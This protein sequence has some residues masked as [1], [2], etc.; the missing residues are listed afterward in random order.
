MKSP[1]GRRSIASNI[2]YRV[3]VCA[4]AGFLASSGS[5]LAEDRTLQF[6]GQTWNVK[7][8]DW[9]P[10]PN[11]WSDGKESVY[12][13]DGRR[14]HLK[15]RQIGGEW[16]CAE[17]WT[18]KSLG[19]G[20]YIFQLASKV[21][22]YDRNIVLGLFTYLDDRHEI[23]IE[24]ARWGEPHNL[25]A[26]FVVQPASRPENLRRFSLGLTGDFSTHRFQWREAFVLFQSYHG[27][28]DALP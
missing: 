7:K 15:I 4:I 26:Q 28:H 27:H 23:D 3:M 9:G 21:E 25:P 8:G 22:K 2:A 1:T 11:H 24:F 17:V 12:V 18:R 20:D 6:A 10:G 13:D 5:S 19:Y 14:L 16:F